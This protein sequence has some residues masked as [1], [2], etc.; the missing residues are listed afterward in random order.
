[1]PDGAEAANHELLRMPLRHL[2]EHG[3]SGLADIS[4]D[5]ERY[6]SSLQS[7]DPDRLGRN[8]ALAFWLNLYN[9]GAL[10]LAGEAQRRGESTVF[11]VPGGFSSRFTNI[12][13]EALSLDDIEHGKIRRFGD[14]RVH[15]AMV[16]GSASCP[17]LCSEP[18][19]GSTLSHQLDDQLRHFLA[20]GG[21]VADHAGNTLD[22]SRIFLWFGADFVRPAR[23]PTLAPARPRLIVDAL[24]E[25]L[26]GELV[27][28]IGSARPRVGF[29]PYRWSLS[30]RVK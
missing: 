12:A 22:L 27:R 15:A 24:A 17:T 18:Y 19:A 14:P 3:P 7:V 20:A 13:G 29:Q 5:I 4:A 8:E 28:W 1:M 11:G 30:C 26:D 2:A 9:A 25:W 23:M 6:V 21:A 10:A 16:C